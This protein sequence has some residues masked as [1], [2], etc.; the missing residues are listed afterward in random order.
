VRRSA[1]RRAVGYR[2]LRRRRPRHGE[3]ESPSGRTSVLDELDRDAVRPDR[4]HRRRGQRVSVEVA[5]LPC[6]RGGGRKR[7]GC[8]RRRAEVR[9]SVT[10][11]PPSAPAPT[12]CAAR[13]EGREDPEVVRR[14]QDVAL[15]SRDG[16]RQAELALRSE[17]QTSVVVL[18]VERGLHCAA[19][20]LRARAEVLDRPIRRSGPDGLRVGNRHHR[21]GIRLSRV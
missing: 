17:D 21:G 11:R 1:A 15:R 10:E 19:Q 16:L 2:D 4:E 6:V 9:E 8:C 5:P 14:R 20:D 13:G 3:D 18:V 7:Q 12:T